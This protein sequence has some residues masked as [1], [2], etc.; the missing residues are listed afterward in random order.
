[1]LAVAE[2]TAL[3]EVTE[4]A[5]AEATGGRGQLEGPQE[6]G[7]L[8]E[9]G[10]DGV[11]LVDQVLDADDAVLAEVLLD[12]VVVGDGQTLLVDLSVTALVDEL[13]DGLLVGVAVGDEGLDDLQHLGGG[14][15]QADEDTVVDL[16]ETEEL[17]R[18]ALL[19]VDL[20]DTLDADDEGELGLSGDEEGAIALGLA[21]G[22]DDVALGLDVLLVVLLGALEDGLALLLVGLRCL[23]QLRCSYLLAQVWG[24]YCG[25]GSAY[26]ALLLEVGGLGLGGLLSSLLLLQNRLG[27]GNVIVG[28]D[29]KNN[30]QPLLFSTVTAVYLR[31]RRT[32]SGPLCW[33]LVGLSVVEEAGEKQ[34]SRCR[35]KLQPS[36]KRGGRAAL[37]PH[38]LRAMPRCV[39]RL[40]T[41]IDLSP[42]QTIGSQSSLQHFSGALLLSQSSQRATAKSISPS[43]SRRTPSIAPMARGGGRVS[44]RIQQ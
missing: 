25:V 35:R 19:G 38:W 39:W 11:D 42:H 13:T 15:G 8:L 21:L 6:V 16:E 1:V 26:L 10:A 23:S 14:L 18:L 33:W 29:A 41:A 28:G 31:G 34:S 9:V 2:V 4:L 44:V 3:D 32:K 24:V 5:G 20:V 27:D 12:Q 37:S 40:A 7:G 17:Q 43:T 36:A 30:N 22:I